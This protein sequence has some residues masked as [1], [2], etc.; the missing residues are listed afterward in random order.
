MQECFERFLTYD[1]NDDNQLYRL[2]SWVFICSF[3]LDL[4]T[5]DKPSNKYYDVIVQLIKLFLYRKPIPIQAR[6]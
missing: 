6:F 3:C 4:Q 2:S 5:L 1:Y